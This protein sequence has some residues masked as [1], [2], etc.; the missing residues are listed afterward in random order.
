MRCDPR[1]LDGEAF[2][3]VVVG[4]GIQGAA[5]A[6]EAALRGLRALLVDARDF[7]A[8]TS[9]RSSRLVHGGLRYLRQGHVALVREA[10]R[11]RERLLRLAPHLVRPLPM[12]MPFFADG[13]GSP[14]LLRL[15][16]LAYALLAGRSTLPPP[17]RLSAA[18]AVSAFPG[19]RT[20][21]L[22][23]ALEFFDARTEDGPLTLANG[24]AAAANGCRIA[25]H[26][27]VVG[28]NERGLSLVDCLSGAQVEVATRHVVNATGPRVDS[29][30]RRLGV[31]R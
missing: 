24:I 18:A 21:G 25:T 10:L 3:V 15:G 6:R 20:R 2:D 30:R 13:G 11:E 14:L 28:A 22:T 31:E 29:L 23:S 4:A 26:T 1:Q 17:R 19:L 5:V 7:A 8:G 27:E 9:S 12:L 16:T